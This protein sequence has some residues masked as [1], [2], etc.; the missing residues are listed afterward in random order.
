MKA[1]EF[2]IGNAILENGDLKCIIAIHSSAIEPSFEYA[3]INETYL[4]QIGFY[5]DEENDIWIHDEYEFCSI[6]LSGKKPFV[7]FLGSAINEDGQLC[8]E[9]VFDKQIDYIH[10]LQNLYYDITDEQIII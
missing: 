10:Q 6:I 9:V 2:R 5:H 8:F 4:T 7:E 3:P 1:D